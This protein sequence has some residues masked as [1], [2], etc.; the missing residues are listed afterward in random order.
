VIR[1]AAGT[2][3]YAHYRAHLRRHH[4]EEQPLS[5]EAFFR[6]ELSARWEGIRR[7]C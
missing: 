4:P 5:R 3:A 1:G 2:D 6:R 7:C